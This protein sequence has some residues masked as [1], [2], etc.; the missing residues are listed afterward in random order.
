MDAIFVACRFAHFS[1]AML[2]FGIS[3]FDGALVPDG[4]RP[5][6]AGLGGRVSAGLVGVLVLTGLAWF[7]LEAGEAGDGWSDVVNPGVWDGLATGT[8]FGAAWMWHLAILAILIVAVLLRGPTRRGL[9][10][11]GSAAV[12]ASLGF[13]GHAAM[14]DGAL[15]WAHRLNHALHLISAGFWVGSLVPLLACLLAL[16]QAA[17]RDDAAIALARFSGFGHVA[18]A[19]VLVTGI[20]NTALTL[21]RAPL[22]PASPY[23]LLLAIKIGLVALMV[24]IAVANRYVF[25]PQLPSGAPRASRGLVLGTVAELAIGV[26]VIGLV[27]AFATFDPV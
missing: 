11:A 15:G 6:L 12:L 23:Q 14:Q 13:V 22:D 4:L 20:V 26:V 8:A 5:R 24:G 7:G 25:T 9:L 17:S 16:R 10:I 18:V 1:A 19:V 2:L 3:V 27:S 21:G